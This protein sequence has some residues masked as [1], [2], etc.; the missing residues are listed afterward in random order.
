LSPG[1]DRLRAVIV[2]VETGH[3]GVDVVRVNCCAE[4]VG[5]HGHS[6]QQTAACAEARS[7]ERWR[8]TAVGGPCATARGASITP[9]ASSA[10]PT[11]T[12]RRCRPRPG[13]TYPTTPATGSFGGGATG[14]VVDD[15]NQ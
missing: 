15:L 10:A 8:L 1:V 11:G 13:A 9:R 4:R 14:D 7:L 5:Q 2:V 6:L 3:E 12:R